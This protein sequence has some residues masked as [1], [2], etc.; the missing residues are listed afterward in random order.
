MSYAPGITY[1]TRALSD[2]I[3]EGLG[4]IAGA[5]LDNAKRRRQKEETAKAIEALQP[6]V[7]KMAPGAGV[8]LDKDVPREMLPQIVQLAGQLDQQQREEPLRR[9][10]LE[11]ERLRQLMRERDLDQAATNAA[12]L[13]AASPFLSPENVNLPDPTQVSSAFQSGRA[14]PAATRGANP[15]RAIS[16]YTRAGG[17]DAHIL[18]QLGDLAQ[19][20][21]RARQVDARNQPRVPGGLQTFGVDAAG[22]PVQG[23]V[24]AQGN[25]RY[26]EPPKTSD[27]PVKPF[28]IGDKNLYR[29]GSTILDDAGKPVK[30]DTEKP[31]DP[32]AAQIAY[33]AYQ[34]AVQEA[35]A[36]PKA[37][38]FDNKQEIAAQTSAK[39]QK[40][41]FLA[42]RL[43]FAAPFPEYDVAK[44]PAIANSA[45]A[46]PKSPDELKSALARGAI[47]L[48]EAKAIATRNGWK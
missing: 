6:L 31:L 44:P 9:I 4:S 32:V 39:R 11:N 28:K 22:R 13:K 23:L 19:T 7:E 24:D 21:V 15:E 46:E 25:V 1:D 29:V 40:A 30:A 43:G 35:A 33:N 45:A 18:A 20:Q 38:W 14:V 16:E 8:R 48:D 3:N 36:E 42:G 41:N 47:T 10:K 5:I 34:L 27:S 2:G 37:G 12:A 26:I 17:V